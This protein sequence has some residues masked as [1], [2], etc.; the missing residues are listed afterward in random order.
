MTDLT[1]TDHVALPPVTDPTTA[2]LVDDAQR[3]FIISK[4]TFVDA[5]AELCTV[6][7]GNIDDLMTALALDPRC[8]WLPAPG[9]EHPKGP[10]PEFK[11]PGKP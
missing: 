8:G 10:M 2:A 6:T 1:S 5:L 7:G 4:V 9:S 3:A 11:F